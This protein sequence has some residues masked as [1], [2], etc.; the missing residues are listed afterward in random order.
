[1]FLS[2][3]KVLFSGYHQKTVKKLLLTFMIVMVLMKLE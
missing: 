2:D 3:G 1:M